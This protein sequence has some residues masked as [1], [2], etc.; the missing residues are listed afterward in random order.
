M[1]NTDRNRLI[2]E[3]LNEGETLSDIQ[4]MLEDEYG[5]RMTY[6]DL[7]ILATEL[8]GVDWSQQPE[9]KTAGKKTAEQEDLLS[10]GGGDDQA[11]ATASGT[12]V[13]VSNVARPGAA[14]S[15]SVEFSSGAKA[16]WFLGNDG[17]LGLQPEAGS[18]KPTEEDI[19]EF[20][21]ELQKKIQGGGGL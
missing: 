15:G 4:K 16:E 21:E 7:R 19:Q 1:D 9:S 18:E 11:A 17:R 5:I 14:M 3:K 13:T 2:V 12:K 20:Q 10:G 8:E 6:M